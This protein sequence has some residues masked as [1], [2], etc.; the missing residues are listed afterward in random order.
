[1]HRG[2]RRSGPGS[3]PE[4]GPRGEPGPRRG[5]RGRHGRGDGPFRQ[6]G[7]RLTA[8][9]QAVLDVVREADGY[10]SAEEVFMEVYRRL[11]GVG[12]ATVYRTLQLLSE[13]GVVSKVA[14]EDG[15]A[16]YSVADEEV[17]PHRVVMVCR[18]C[19]RTEA[20]PAGSGAVEE[21]TRE[22]SREVTAAAGFAVEQSVHQFYGVCHECSR[23][24]A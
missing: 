13:L 9:R 1:M 17:R 19:H 12:I 24:R 3:R 2:G 15:K 11:P 20:L 18:R 14:S 5:P 8:P 21:R 7:F 22:L 6:G 4:P 16:R 10:I 23:T